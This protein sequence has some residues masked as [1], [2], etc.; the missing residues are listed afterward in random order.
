MILEL[1]FSRSQVH[2][3]L[4]SMMNVIPVMDILNGQVVHAVGGERS[5]YKPIESVLTQSSEPVEV[6]IAF[7]A[8]GFLQVYIAD[9]DAII[10]CTR[11]DFA[12]LKEIYQKTGLQLMVDAGITSL[13]RAKQMFDVGVSKIVIGTETMQNTNFV[14]DAVERFGSEHVVVS[15]DLKDAKVL[16]GDGFEGCIDALCMLTEFKEMGIESLIVLDLTRVGSCE[17]VDLQFL[18]KA[19]AIVPNVYAGG[20]VRKIGD[21]VELQKSGI[22]GA[23]IA[24]A[25]HTGKISVTELRAYGFL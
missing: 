3:S 11:H 18:K 1:G 22:S 12:L 23:L 25:L 14:R 15:L 19:K 4:A 17:G 13:E 10:D 16:V 7:K 20:G 21:L 5:R 8:N 6:A 9:L 24:T 2:F